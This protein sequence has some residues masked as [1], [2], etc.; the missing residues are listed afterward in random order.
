[1]AP[2]KG[3]LVVS[4]LSRQSVQPAHEA[5][6][7]MLRGRIEVAHQDLRPFVR[8]G[9]HELVEEDDLLLALDAM[10][11]AIVKMRAVGLDKT[12]G[13]LDPGP[14]NSSNLILSGGREH[15]ALMGGDGKA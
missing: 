9:A 2:G 4:A 1:M 14:K 15:L 13:R 10:S 12:R 3:V 5:D 11:E 7:V 6:F 8:M